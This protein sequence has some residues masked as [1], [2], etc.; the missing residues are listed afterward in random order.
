LTLCEI[1]WVSTL[2][3]VELPQMPV[4]KRPSQRTAGLQSN[5]L[6]ALRAVLPKQL[7][8]L[9]AVPA[10]RGCASSAPDLQQHS[11]ILI[12]EPRDTRATNMS[13]APLCRASRSRT[14]D[15]RTSASQLRSKNYPIICHPL[16]MRGLWPVTVQLQ[17]DREDC[18][19]VLLRG[20]SCCRCRVLRQFVLPIS[21]VCR[22]GDRGKYQ[23]LIRVTL[24]L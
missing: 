18:A 12:Q 19:A 1:V 3:D 5:C 24:L 6:P 2:I 4:R 13:P 17:S 20:N 15:S 11:G 8:P 7:C 14:I 23:D 9:T 10:R 21:S 22:R 16:A